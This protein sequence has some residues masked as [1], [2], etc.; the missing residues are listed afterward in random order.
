[1]IYE[2]IFLVMHKYIYINMILIIIFN[3]MKEKKEQKE[4]K[5]AKRVKWVKKGEKEKKVQ[6]EKRGQRGEMGEEGVKEQ[7]Q[8]IITDHVSKGGDSRLLSK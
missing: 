7:F 3:N 5:G 1:M 8:S 6:K 2:Y 4:K